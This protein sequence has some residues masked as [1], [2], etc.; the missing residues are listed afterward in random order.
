MAFK[1]DNRKS[2][3]I[4]EDFSIKLTISG[5]VAGAV[6]ETSRLTGRPIEEVVKCMTISGIKHGFGVT[7]CWIFPY[8]T[9]KKLIADARELILAKAGKDALF[10]PDWILDE[11]A[12]KEHMKMLN[13][14]SETSA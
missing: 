6:I 14:E 13:I 2:N 7:G 1:F 11:S 8:S 3:P 10:D 4:T 5:I 12:I 9:P